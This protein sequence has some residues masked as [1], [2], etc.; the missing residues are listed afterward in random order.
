MKTQLL[1]LQTKNKHLVTNSVEVK[2]AI[3]KAETL[4][5]K[6]NELT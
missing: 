2:K 5:L 6:Y 4:Q 3:N 1:R